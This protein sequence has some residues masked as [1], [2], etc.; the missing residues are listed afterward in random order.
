MFDLDR[1]TEIYM[2]IKKHKLRTFLTAFGVFWGIFMLVVL[3]GSSNGFQNGVMDGFNIKA[4][5]VFVWTERTTM[6]FKGLKPGRYI[7]LTNDDVQALRSGIPELD[8]IAA[9]NNLGTAELK[10]EEKN[11]NFRVFGDYPDFAEV[12]DLNLQKG[13]F[14]NSID[15]ENRRK[16]AIIG[17]RVREVL[18]EEDEDPLGKYIQIRGVY[19]KVVGLTKSKRKGE[20]GVRDNERVYIPATTLQQTYNMINRVHWFALTPKDGISATVI[21]EKAKSLLASRHRVHPDDNPAFGSA[22]IE[23]EYKQIMGLF[24]GIKGFGWFV[25]VFTIIA[26]VIG[27]S[28]IMLIIVKERTKE[29]GVRKALGARPRSIIG[30]IL[31]ESLIITGFSGYFGLVAGVGVIETINYL[32]RKYEVEAEF[33]ANPEIDFK[34]ALSALI[35]LTLSGTI[36]GLFPARKAAQ[37]Q[38][39]VALQDE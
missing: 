6:P 16:V 25:S 23:K 14:V 19:F 15:I 38:P 22:N 9:R 18:F 17:D 5:T 7:R 20:R 3:L 32:M 10:N 4:N 31:Q 26:G 39:V 27:V 29:I 35:V 2:S 30:M 34:V 8:L 1:W 12:E 33:F 21:E 11:G 37:V 24:M 13:R 28:N 36:A